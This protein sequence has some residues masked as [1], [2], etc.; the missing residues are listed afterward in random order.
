M[1][2]WI[3][4]HMFSDWFD[5]LELNQI[6]LRGVFAE[7]HR[8]IDWGGHVYTYQKVKGWKDGGV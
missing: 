4:S 3:A 7:E 2:I 6:F 8:F 1:S 5:E